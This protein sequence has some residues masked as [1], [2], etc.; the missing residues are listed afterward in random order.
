[1]PL[2]TSVNLYVNLVEGNS[3]RG[4][5]ES[6]NYPEVILQWVL[7]VVG[8]TA[9]IR[10]VKTVMLFT[11]LAYISFGLMFAYE[12]VLRETRLVMYRSPVNFRDHP[13]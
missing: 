11:C 4:D 5:V 8:Y 13:P 9:I 10:S 6:F 12:E 2:V 7:L 1:M 3:P